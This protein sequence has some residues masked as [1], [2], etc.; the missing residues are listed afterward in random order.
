MRK[1]GASAVRE[2]RRQGQKEKEL[3][4]MKGLAK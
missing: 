3:Q 4:K 1:D 2:R